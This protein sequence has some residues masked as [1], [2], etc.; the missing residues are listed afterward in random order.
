MYGRQ[1]IAMSMGND[2]QSPTERQGRADWTGTIIGALLVPVFFFFV[3]LGKPEMGFNVCIVLGMVMLAVKLRWK[4]R[5]HAWFW[6]VIALIFALHIPFLFIVRWPQTQIP[7]IAFSL[8]LGIVDFLLIS[9][10]IGLA[11]KVF[12][13]PPD[14]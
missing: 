6:G 7:T 4:L 5:R 2:E 12:S 13:R 8:P 3:Y 1:L 14:K 11:E 9:G 10:A